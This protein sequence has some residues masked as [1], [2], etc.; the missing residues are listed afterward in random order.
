MGM[1]E[2]SRLSSVTI[3][4][5]DFDMLYYQRTETTGYDESIAYSLLEKSKSGTNEFRSF[6]SGQTFKSYCAVPIMSDD[7]VRGMICV[8]EYDPAE[9]E[10]VIALRNNL[11]KIS[12][13]LGLLAVFLSMIYSHTFTKRITKILD[14]IGN[15]R[16]G[17]YTYRIDVVGHDELA[18]LSDEFNSL[19]GRLQSTEEIRRRFVADASHELKTPLASIRLLSD[20]ILQNPDIDKDTAREFVSDIKDE[21][22]R[23]A[24][25]T[26]QLLNLTKLDN[27]TTTI[28]SDVDCCKIG[29][30]VIRAL[31]PIA[32]QKNVTINSNFKNECH[33]MATDD[34]LFQIIFNLGENAIKYNFNGGT[35]D[36]DIYSDMENAVISISDSGIGIPSQDLPYI[37]DRF[38]RVDKSR[39]REGGGSG[40]G[41]SIV[42]STAERHGGEVKAEKND[43]GGMKFIVSFPLYYSGSKVV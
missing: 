17:E 28:R 16:E 4:N 37:F 9:G 40:L 38:Y 19:T 25:T 31:R 1:L 14:A 3:F 13:G 36:I 6:F 18:Q 22:E 15:V 42:K 23:L 29:E 27:N 11:F 32:E 5:A 35:V 2:T 33:I 20:S 10:I 34:E 8:Y 26:E 12:I 41:L 43:V 21:S 30:R 39:G 7:Q 24:R